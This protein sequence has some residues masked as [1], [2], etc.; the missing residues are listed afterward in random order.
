MVNG[1]QQVSLENSKA[2]STRILEMIKTGNSEAAARN[3]DFLLRSGLITDP[4]RVDKVAAF[5]RNLPP[6]AGPSLPAPSG[7]EALSEG[8][9]QSLQDY[10]ANLDKLGFPAG[11]PIR[12]K[13]E[14]TP[15]G[16]SA[17]YLDNMIVIDP[18]LATDRS[19]PF[20][21]YSHHVLTS[22]LK[23]DWEGHYAAIESGVADYLACSY[24]NNPK[25]GEVAAKAFGLK[26][27]FIRNLANDENF[28]DFKNKT[29][30]AT[31]TE[32]MQMP[33]DGAKVW[34]GALW[35]IRTA[36]G[37]DVADPIVA[38]A[39]LAMNWSSADTAFPLAFTTALL[40]AA[41]QKAPATTDTVKAILQSR[42]FP[43]PS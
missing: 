14:A 7:T 27:P 8:V 6:G 15:A 37:R 29:D 26:D 36:L 41:K 35:A 22:K 5:L 33:Y 21:E 42:K 18:K 4:E 24:L 16:P 28:A 39:W 25:F 3:L 34:G 13:V 43:L 32:R 2:E 30:K 40:D 38:A 17:Y 20:R 23:K 11:E 1:T 9:K 31:S 10:I 19:V 12:V